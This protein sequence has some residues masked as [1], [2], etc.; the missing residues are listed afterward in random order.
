MASHLPLRSRTTKWGHT[1]Q[2]LVD[3]KTMQPIIYVRV[4]NA[5]SGSVIETKV[6]KDEDAYLAYVESLIG[7]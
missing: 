7:N 3:R 5:A 1:A 6:V 2:V 4:T